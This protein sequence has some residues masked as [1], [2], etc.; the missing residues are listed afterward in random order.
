MHMS[1]ASML[2]HVALPPSRVVLGWPLASKR[3][4]AEAALR[5]SHLEVPEYHLH[6]MLLF[7]VLKPAQMK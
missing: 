2:L 1:G 4:E 7:K 3:E 5:K 6:S